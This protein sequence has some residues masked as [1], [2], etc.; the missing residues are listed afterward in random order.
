MGLEYYIGMAFKKLLQFNKNV[1]KYATDQEKL[2]VYKKV[3][4]YCD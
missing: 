4:K 2:F 3:Q 1:V